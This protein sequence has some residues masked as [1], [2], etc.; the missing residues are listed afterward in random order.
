M[1]RQQLP[2]Q[3]LA[4]VL[5]GGRGTRLQQL[6]DRRA[7]PAVYFGGKF[8]IV[9]F[10]LSNCVNSGIRR[11]AVVTQY[12]AH[13]LLRHVQRGW[14]FMRPGVNEFIDLMP[15]QQRMGET[16][17]YRGTAD[18]VTQNIDI[19]QAY[20]PKYLVILAGDHV[21]K[22]DYAAMLAWHVDQGRPC[23]VACVEV[24]LEEAT[25]YGVMAADGSNR[26]TQ[27]VEKPA[28]PPP[29][30]GRPD[31]ALASMGIYVFDA[32]YLYN[33]LRQDG[34]DPK[35]SHDFGKDV[36]PK[37]VA[38][39][40]ASAHPFALSCVST[41]PEDEPYWRDV[42]TLDGYWRA[43]LDLTL[44]TPA[45]DMYDKNWPIWTYQEQL[46]PAKF[47]FDDEQRRGA[48]VD[49]LVSGGCIISGSI[50][51]RSV[52]FSGCRVNSYCT[53]EDGVL[54][55]EVEVG[56]HARLK[57]VI[58]DHGCHVPE[59]LVIGEDAEADARRFTRTDGGVTLVTQE[60]LRR[61]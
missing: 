43:N 49:S 37:A 34:Q 53:V 30:I 35:S 7:K 23:T 29:V 12:N 17:W 16:N 1:S 32:E 38:A 36:I 44:P 55:P 48:A 26:V 40:E 42:G 18:A 19:L 20:K 57:R 54:L 11:I 3:S 41:A 28:N 2:Q 4:L 9:D 61:L 13:S 6:C 52:L 8:R 5:A 25:Q 59:G 47:V 51:R 50:V 27:F 21:Y 56:R 46:A 39:G 58:V 45:L 60:M 31:R 22:M 33:A 10:A 24:P 15:A 14:A